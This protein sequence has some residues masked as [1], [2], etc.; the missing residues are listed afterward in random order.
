MSFWKLND[1][2]SQGYYLPVSNKAARDQGG[3][4]VTGLFFL[5][6]N[7]FKLAGAILMGIAALLVMIFSGLW[8][9]IKN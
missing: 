2:E 6:V 5:V 1:D 7:L 4:L 9:L 8:K 3:Q